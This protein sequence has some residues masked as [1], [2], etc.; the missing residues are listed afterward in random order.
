MLAVAPRVLGAL[1]FLAQPADASSRGGG[2]ISIIHGIVEDQSGGAIS[3]AEVSVTCGSA[4]PIT[5]TSSATGTFELRNV[6]AAHCTVTGRRDPFEPASVQLDLTGRASASVR[7][8]L[9]IARFEAGV[10]VTPSLGDRER[11]VDV[12]EAVTVATHEE[13]GARA[14]Q[15]LPVGLREETG[16][17]VQQST[18]AQGSP[19]IRGFSAQRIVYLLDGVRLNTSTFRAGATQYLAWINPGLVDRLEV[20]RGP[21]SV[22]YGSDSL[23]GTINVLTFRPLRSMNERRARGFFEGTVASADRSGA[24]SAGANV[25]LQ[26]FRFRAGG[27]WRRVNDLR[28]GGG[29]DSHAAVTRFLGLASATTR[30]GLP[31]TGFSQS[32]GYVLADIDV[33]ASARVT[34][35]Y[36]HEQQVGVHRYH[37][38]SGG[39]GLY[40]SEFDPQAI[41]FASLRLARGPTGPLQ[42]WSATFS[43]NRQQDGRIEQARP[44]TVIDRQRG[45]VSSLGYQFRA[46][47]GIGS[48]TTMALGAEVYDEYITANRVL[49]E[50][51]GGGSEEVRPPIP[52]GTRYTSSGAFGQASVQLERLTLRTGIRYGHFA[53]RTPS[54][55]QFAVAAERVAASAVTFSSGA[56]YQLKPW[57][58]LTGRVSRGFRAAN[59]FD[60]GSIGLTGGGFE[61]SPTAAATL[62]G[63]VGTDAGPNATPTDRAVGRL[64]PES[65]YAFEGGVKLQHQTFAASFTAFSL[66]LVDPIQRRTVLFPQSIVGAVISGFEV[67]SQDT[68][69]RAFVDADPRPIVTR[70]NGEHARIAGIEADVQVRIGTAWLASV[71][72]ATA[73]GHDLE[74]GQFLRRMPPTFGAVSLKYEPSVSSLWVEAVATWALRQTRL[75]PGDLGD[76]RIGAA[77]SRDAIAQFFDGTATD[78]GLVQNGVLAATGE[79][80]AQ[81]QS[82]VLGTAE[83]APLFTSTPGFL[84]LALRGGW[85]LGSDVTLTIVAENL[86]DHSYRWHGSGTDAPG[87]NAQV[88]L[89]YAF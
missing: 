23:G 20:V 44:T 11:T 25:D 64:Q 34:A 43:F 22:Q 56:V 6:P 46:T 74:T 49:L 8:V 60:L 84:T 88:K 39:D 68:E 14:F 18:P 26:G 1:L 32:G 27:S 79:T 78:M 30:S 86:T 42:A 73:R 9:P 65:V 82:R 83:S 69:E 72:A 3:G 10:V 2:G 70:A 85:R 61:L 53:F 12:P 21:A 36:L 75:S 16:V 58:N 45:Q 67:V 63:V 24:G 57:L 66:E 55:P 13:L 5:T 89:R 37:R 4:Q 51:T 19:F 17:L 80:L 47:T 40:R 50:P 54:Q 52:D 59:A 77:R 31:G 62:G 81:V 76:A 41:D 38:L 71:N 15:I 48:A 35:T 33:G 7:L 87:V 28:T 29:R